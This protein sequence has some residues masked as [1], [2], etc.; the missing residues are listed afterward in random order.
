MGGVCGVG[1]VEFVCLVEFVCF[2]WS[3]FACVFVSLFA[4]PFA[5]PLAGPLAGVNCRCPFAA[6]AQ[7]MY[8]FVPIPSVQQSQVYNNPRCSTQSALPTFYCGN[9]VLCIWCR[10][11][12]LFV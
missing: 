5:G 8:K 2:G 6:L 3:L 12:K 10:D 1:G 11:T 4:G 9:S 7:S